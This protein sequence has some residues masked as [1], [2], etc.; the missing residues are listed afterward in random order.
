M[1]RFL[2]STFHLLSL[3]GTIVGLTLFLSACG[4]SFRDAQKANTIEAYES[5]LAQANESDPFYFQAQVALFEL[6]LGAARDA[7]TLEEYDRF[8]ND[9]PD[10]VASLKNIREK[11]ME[12]RENYFYAWAD[13]LGTRKAWEKFLEEYPHTERKRKIEARR[14][15]HMADNMNRVS[16]SSIRQERINLAE[17]PEGPLN[18]WG[19]WC[20]VTNTGDK[21]IELLQLGIYYLD[22]DGRVLD[23]DMWPVVAKALPG[24]LPFAEGFDKPMKPGETRTWEWTSGDFPADWARKVKVAPVHIILVGEEDPA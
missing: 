2:S 4:P 3:R 14:R 18:G 21:P 11:A 16:L 22:D 10:D 5:Y 8:L 13:E 17:D 24:Y 15:M 23:R 12:E 7:G 1:S 20:E 6:R 19:F 9:L